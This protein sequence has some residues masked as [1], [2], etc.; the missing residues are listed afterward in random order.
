MR[1]AGLNRGTLRNEVGLSSDGVELPEAKEMIEQLLQAS[2]EHHQQEL[3]AARK[4]ADRACKRLQRTVRLQKSSIQQ[5][6]SKKDK[7]EES[8]ALE[9]AKRSA[10]A[11]ELK[12]RLE[13][14]EEKIAQLQ[15]PVQALHAELKALRQ[16]MPGF[17]EQHAKQ[18][19]CGGKSVQR[20]RAATARCAG[21][22]AAKGV[23]QMHGEEAA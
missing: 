3:R 11:S 17:E 21:A 23:V 5:L 16:Y 7:L 19:S 6:L 15:V 13:E 9:T 10:V 18:A 12:V 4:A 14:S 8:A 22:P 2:A 1:R 20:A